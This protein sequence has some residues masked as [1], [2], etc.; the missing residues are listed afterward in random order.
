VYVLLCD[1]SL[2]E[3][4]EFASIVYH[5][6]QMHADTLWILYP[7][8]I[9]TARCSY[10]STVLGVVILP[11]CPSICHMR[12]LWL[13]QRTY[14]RYFYTTFWLQQTCTRKPAFQVAVN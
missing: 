12:A 2:K 5:K 14:Q 10:A 11:V 1:F 3:Y 9:I 8:I 6:K 4:R 7:M 13:I